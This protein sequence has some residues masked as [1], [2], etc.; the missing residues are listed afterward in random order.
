LRWGA[1]SAA[2]L[3][4]AGGVIFLMG[5][6]EPK[7]DQGGA[8][9]E[10]VAENKA[11]EYQIKAFYLYNFLLFTDWPEPNEVKGAGQKSK[12]DTREEE[13]ITIGIVGKDPFGEHFI[14]VEGK[15]VKGKGKRL[16]IKRFGS[17]QK[18][19]ELEKCDLLF[20]SRFQK[21]KIRDILWHV[22]GH[23]VLTVADTDGFLEMG[24]MVNLVSIKNKIR[25]E[26][27]ITPVKQSGLRL[28]SQLLRNAVRVVEVSKVE[29]DRKTNMSS[30]RDQ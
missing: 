6:A 10:K 15:I 30:L 17:Y 11:S 4:S 29:E 24:G 8:Y 20:L 3:L 28:S 14:E 21:Q 26:I 12:L 18:G 5:S 23:A 1:L 7:S 27:N 19:F 16:V 2:V 9:V 25:W 13:V 22:E